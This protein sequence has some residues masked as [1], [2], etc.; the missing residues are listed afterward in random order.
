MEPFSVSNIWTLSFWLTM[1]KKEATCHV[2]FVVIELTTL[3]FPCDAGSDGGTDVLDLM[4]GQKYWIINET[5]HI[6]HNRQST[7]PPVSC[8]HRSLKG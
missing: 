7:I 2:N 4:K 5:A 1:G 8:P 3:V 6:S